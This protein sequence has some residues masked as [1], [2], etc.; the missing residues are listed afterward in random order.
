MDNHYRQAGPLIK[1]SFASLIDTEVA[2]GK[3]AGTEMKLTPAK[4]PF[5]LNRYD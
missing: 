2:S 1:D 5:E 3:V 4:G